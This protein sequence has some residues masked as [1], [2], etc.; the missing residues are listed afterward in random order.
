MTSRTKSENRD[1]PRDR[2]GTLMSPRLEHRRQQAI[3]RDLA[4]DKIET[5]CR[6]IGCSK[7]WLYTW[8]D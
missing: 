5:I 3:A 2:K 1:Q 7:S 6:E 4:G 8:R